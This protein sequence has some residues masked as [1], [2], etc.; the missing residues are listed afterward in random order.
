MQNKQYCLYSNSRWI[1]WCSFNALLLDYL[2][3]FIFISTYLSIKYDMLIFYELLLWLPTFNW[4][5][6]WMFLKIGLKKNCFICI[7]LKKQQTEAEQEALK[8]ICMP[9]FWFCSLY[10]TKRFSVNSTVQK[11]SK[12]SVHL[13]WFGMIVTSHKGNH[14]LFQ[15]WYLTKAQ[16]IIPED[17]IIFL[18]AHRTFLNC[19]A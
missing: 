9:F 12:A 19:S 16:L 18:R 6:L 5:R 3:F 13:L 17:E 8:N 11:K 1:T 7:I 14:R 2:I 15:F 4:Q 10:F